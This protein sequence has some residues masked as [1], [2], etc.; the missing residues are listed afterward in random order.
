MR[1]KVMCDDESCCHSVAN[2]LDQARPHAV[3]TR[4]RM[5]R[6]LDEQPHR[7]W[8]LNHV[9]RQAKAAVTLATQAN[10]LLESEGE[11]QRIKAGNLNA[12]AQVLSQLG[13][14]DFGSRSA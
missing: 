6:Q 7:R 8:R 1:P 5:L 14:D 11:K 9:A 4:A 13:E 10:K 3:R 2:T 12:L